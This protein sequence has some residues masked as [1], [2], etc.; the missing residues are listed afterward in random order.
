MVQWFPRL[1]AC[2]ESG[3][4]TTNY[5][6]TTVPSPDLTRVHRHHRLADVTG[7]GFA[8]LRKVLDGSLDAPLAGAVGIGARLDTGRLLALIAT[9][10][11]T[12]GDK[13]ALLRCVSVA[14]AIG[15][16][17]FSGCAFPGQRFLERPE[18]DTQTAI[19]G[20]VFTQGQSSVEVLTG[21]N[22]KPRVLIGDA[23][24][25]LVELGEVI[26]REPVV[27]VAM[28]VEFGALVVEAV[29]HLVPNHHA[30]GAEVYRRIDFVVIKRRLENA[31]REVDVDLRA[32]IVGVDRRRS[33]APLRLVDGLT[34]LGQISVRFELIG[35][36]GVPNRVVALDHQ[37][38]VVAPVVR[39]ADLSLHRGQFGL[40]LNLGLVAHPRQRLDVQ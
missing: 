25:A 19:V 21:C 20:G 23:F 37:C 8:E 11:L 12:V 27:S 36:F 6:L 31:G 34:Q 38:A 5:Q 9:P 32:R 3:W 28:Q 33:Y 24:G 15:I 26:L 7:E 18:R 1:N 22:L 10:D 40:G 14:L 39:V 4:P 2:P 30:D 13:V 35:A 29:G 17:G 16:T